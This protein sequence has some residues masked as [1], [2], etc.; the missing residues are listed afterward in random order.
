[1]HNVFQG[2]KETKTSIFRPFVGTLSMPMPL[3]RCGIEPGNRGPVIAHRA[4]LKTWVSSN[5]SAY[6]T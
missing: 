1:M 5:V 3:V 6:L 2:T 4:Q